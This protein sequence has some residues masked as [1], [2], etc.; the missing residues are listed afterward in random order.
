[1]EMA[2]GSPGVAAGLGIGASGVVG[3][4]LVDGRVDRGPES[5]T[6]LVAGDVGIPSRRLAKP[7]PLPAPATFVC[8]FEL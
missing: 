3:Y 5:G 2:S 7:P 4:G 6:D 1:M 8:S